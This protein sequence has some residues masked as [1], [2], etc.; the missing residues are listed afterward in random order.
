VTASRRPDAL[1][2]PALHNA[3]AMLSRKR[4]IALAGA[5]AG[6]LVAGCGGED[7]EA[8][9]REAR[10]AADREIVRYLLDVER[11]T[12][13]FWDQVAGRNALAEAGVGELAASI[14]RNERTH[15]EVLERFARRLGGDDADGAARPRPTFAAV[16]AAGP[17]E[18]LN[19]AAT[20]TNLGAA[21]Y[22]GQANRIEDR[23][24]L[25]SV[26]AIHSVEGRQAAVVNRLAGRGFS[27]GTGE[28]SGA[29]PDGGFAEPMAM[30]EVR[31][32]LRR[33]LS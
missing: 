24:L 11:V 3:A 31:V 7:D 6:T 20:L 4:F 15:V 27:L 14:A 21:A 8:R 1:V 13:A 17:Q 10:V 2:R 26:L 32:R 33:I 22:L 5:S 12:T 30:Q 25:A 9:E 16:F 23:N 28:L 29:L 18:V 19:T